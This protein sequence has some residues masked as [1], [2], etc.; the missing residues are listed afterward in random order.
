MKDVTEFL[1]EYGELVPVVKT[2]TLL[3][4]FKYFLSGQYVEANNCMCMTTEKT[5][6]KIE[7]ESYTF[8]PSKSLSDKE[9]KKIKLAYPFIWTDE[10]VAEVARKIGEIR[11]KSEFWTGG[12]ENERDIIKAFKKRSELAKMIDDMT[13]FTTPEQESIT[14]NHSKFLKLIQ[15]LNSNIKF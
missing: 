14:L 13:L 2:E 11:I 8:E 3:K 15:E 10:K 1:K 9:P 12:L 5:V 4:A 7:S 6:N